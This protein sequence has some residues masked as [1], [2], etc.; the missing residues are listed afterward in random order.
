MDKEKFEDIKRRAK[1][2]LAERS[3]S[4]NERAASE[5][6]PGEWTTYET[7]DSLMKAV[8]SKMD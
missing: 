7:A 1:A 8:G 6:T 4:K 3:A 2:R 5:D